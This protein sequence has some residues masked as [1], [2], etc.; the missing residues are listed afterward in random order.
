MMCSKEIDATNLFLPWKEESSSS[1][2]HGKEILLLSN[3]NIKE[4]VVAPKNPDSLTCDKQYYHFGLRISTTASAQEF[5]DQWNNNKYNL[6]EKYPILKTVSMKPS[7][8]QTSSTA[9][10]V[11]YFINSTERG[12]Y[13]TL[14]EELTKMTNYKVEVSFQTVNQEKV[15]ATIWNNTN[16]KAEAL[17]INPK[18][19]AFCSAKYK[20][21]PA[22]LVVYVD[23]K[24]HVKEVR[25]LMY[26]KYGVIENENEWPMIPDGSKMVFVPII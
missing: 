23:K 9:Y 24:E 7:E 20:D 4:Y 2:I 5:T 14:N 21:S 18:S 22:A 12:D 1:P 16:S 10:A 15:S 25:R 6:G 3:D 26:D 13:T 8:M 11:G 19:K 17:D